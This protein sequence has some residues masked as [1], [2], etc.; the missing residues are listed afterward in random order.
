LGVQF[1]GGT[2]FSEPDK[3]SLAQF[4]GFLRDGDVEKVIL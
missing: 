3:T 4:E 2:G 1:F